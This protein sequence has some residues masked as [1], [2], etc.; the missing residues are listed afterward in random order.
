[1][2]LPDWE[3]RLRAAIMDA[4]PKLGAWGTNDCG[5]F[6][7]VDCVTAVLGTSPLSQYVGTYDTA[8]GAAELVNQL[9]DGGGFDMEALARKYFAAKE[10]A[11]AI[12]GDIGVV[13]LQSIKTLVIVH[14]A[15][16]FAPGERC[17]ARLPR[18]ALIAAFGVD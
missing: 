14:G 12:D 9:T 6:V 5:T 10:P 4:R 17:Q 18:T 15:C 1:M 16:V 13:E 2:R 11:T 8:E 3:P 7:L